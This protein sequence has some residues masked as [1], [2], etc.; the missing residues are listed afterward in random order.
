ML[1]N[2]RKKCLLVGII[3]MSLLLLVWT[4][5]TDGWIVPIDVRIEYWL[6]ASRSLS[7]NQFFTF[8][9]AFGNWKFVGLSTLLITALF[10][11]HGRKHNAFALL[12]TLIGAEATAGISKLILERPRPMGIG[13]FN[14]T[15]FS[16]PSGHATVALAFYGFLG[17]LL[18]RKKKQP[19][20]KRVVLILTTLVILLVGFSRL[21]LGLHYLSDV[22][23]GYLISTIWLLIGIIIMKRKHLNHL[24]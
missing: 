17:Y 23:G 6:Y 16:F 22:I 1:S 15:S 12:T 3:I 24:F 9:T 4:V 10:A 5:M 14:E 20:E 7:W 8:V 2:M 19:L 11:S 13:V 18:W 21:Y